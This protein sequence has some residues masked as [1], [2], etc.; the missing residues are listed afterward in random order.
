VNITL[1]GLIKFYDREAASLD[2]PSFR[3][4][5]ELRRVFDQQVTPW[6]GRLIPAA[7]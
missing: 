5:R 4:R 7:R 6:S 1:G 3:T 2:G